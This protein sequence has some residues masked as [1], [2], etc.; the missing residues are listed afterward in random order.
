ML[1]LVDPKTYDYQLWVLLNINHL[2]CTGITPYLG[3]LLTIHRE[4]KM[5]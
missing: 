5:E 1:I 4:N 3:Y 2:F